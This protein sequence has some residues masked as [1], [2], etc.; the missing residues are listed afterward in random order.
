MWDTE[1]R[2]MDDVM[3]GE[4]WLGDGRRRRRREMKVTGRVV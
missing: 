1:T 3:V 2:G 4:R